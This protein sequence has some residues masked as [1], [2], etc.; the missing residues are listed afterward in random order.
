MN[1][2]HLI[3]NIHNLELKKEEIHLWFVNLNSKEFS[4]INY[5]PNSLEED[6]I[7]KLNSMCNKLLFINRRKFLKLL[8]SKYEKK[9]LMEIQ[10]NSNKNGKEEIKINGQASTLNF[11]LSK[12][13]NILAISF[14][15]NKFLGIDIEK[16]DPNII[17][18]INQ[19]FNPFDKRYFFQKWTEYEALLKALGKGIPNLPYDN[20]STFKKLAKYYKNPNVFKLYFR[21]FPSY[22]CSLI[23]S[24]FRCIKFFHLVD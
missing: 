18:D 8:I 16:E 9:D 14:S 24:S 7:K 17:E 4:I 1:L 2:K 5:F 23:T 11:S 19:F 12:S 15:Y 10:I 22:F 20:P 3:H 6:R 13:G 21:P